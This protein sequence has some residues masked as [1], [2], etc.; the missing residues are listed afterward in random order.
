MKYSL[1]VCCFLF[2]LTVRAQTDTAKTLVFKVSNPKSI[3]KVWP[4]DTFLVA[5]KKNYIRIEVEGNNTLAGVEMKGGTI[6]KTASGDYEVEV[7]RGAEVILNVY[8]MNPLGE[9]KLG[10]NKRYAIFKN[11]VPQVLICGVKNDS[12]IDPKTL[13]ELGKVTAEIR[14]TSNVIQRLR[15]HSFE[16][17]YPNGNELDTLR[18]NNHKLTIAMRRMIHRN[19]KEGDLL[20]FEQVRCTMPN[21]KKVVLEPVTLYV[22]ETNKY[23]I[24]THEV[25]RPGR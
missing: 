9:V 20:Y 3:I 5:G 13:I 4:K 23:R 17:L 22:D 24:G 14:D 2:A 1:I 21:G 11:P 19:L 16:M 10:L 18:S 6:Q 25:T 7:N 12:T 8:A 15:V